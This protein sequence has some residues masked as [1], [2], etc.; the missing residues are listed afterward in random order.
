MEGVARRVN[1]GIIGAMDEENVVEFC[2]K[3]EN[4]SDLGSE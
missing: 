3:E 2:R 1:G 4:Q